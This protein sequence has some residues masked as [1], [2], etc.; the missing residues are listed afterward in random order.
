[1]SDGDHPLAAMLDAAARGSYP[2]PDGDV[3]LLAPLTGAADAMIGFTGHFVLTA[4]VPPDEFRARVPPGDF[5]VPMSAGSLAWIA[6]CS[7]RRPGTFDAALACGGGGAGAPEW[8]VPLTDTTHPR[9]ARA[10]RYRDDVRVWGTR[11]GDG[12][13]VV[14]RGLCDRWELAFEVEPAA[15]GRGLGR[16]LASAARD[17]VPAGATLWAQV[18]PANAASLRAVL[19]AGFRPVAAEVLFV[20][21]G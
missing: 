13:L 11:D 14:G 19:A 6:A 4:R 16:R 8:L 20:P 21:A 5:S 1:M 12:V 10:R 17:V 3:E 15:R 9:I 18:A 2:E 7:G